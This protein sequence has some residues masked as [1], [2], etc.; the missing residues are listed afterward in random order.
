ML[1]VPKLV[2]FHGWTLIIREMVERKAFL[3]YP[4]HQDCV[5][6]YGEHDYSAQKKKNGG[7]YEYPSL[8]NF[9]DEG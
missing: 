1:R 9:M 5:S 7:Y 3:A 8:S 4:K 6:K 2:S